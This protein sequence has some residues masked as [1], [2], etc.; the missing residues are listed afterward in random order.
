MSLPRLGSDHMPIRLEVGLHRSNPSPFQYELVWS[1]Y[2]GFQDLVH[3]KW[4]ELSP[5]GCGA[6]IF[7]KKVAGV[8]AV[9]ALG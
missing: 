1:T 6:F 7:P 5:C 2:D 9:K 8:R 3:Q 4:M